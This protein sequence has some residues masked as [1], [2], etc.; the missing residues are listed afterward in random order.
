MEVL[1]LGF[2]LGEVDNSI[3]T[4]DEETVM[5]VGI[6]GYGFGVSGQGP[7]VTGLTVCWMTQQHLDLTIL[8]CWVVELVISSGSGVPQ[9]CMQGVVLVA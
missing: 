4:P 1:I 6:M 9:G 2:A 5:V 3:S 7:W 8:A